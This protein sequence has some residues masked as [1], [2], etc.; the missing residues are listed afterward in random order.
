MWRALD[1]A[2]RRGVAEGA[3]PG[4]VVLAGDSREILFHRAYGH[5]ALAPE[6]LSMM[7]DTV[8]DLSSLTKPVATTTAMMLLVRD[9]RVRL[10]DPVSR[11]IPEFSAEA[12]AAVTFRQLLNHT[13]GLPA[14]KPYYESVVPAPPSVI[15]APS[16]V[17]PAEAGIQAGWGGAARP[18]GPHPPLDSRFRGNDGEGRGNDE[19]SRG[20]DREGRG[21]TGEGPGNEDVGGGRILEQIHAEPLV[22]GPGMGVCYSD[23]GFML[24][25]EAVERLTGKRLDRLCRDEVFVPLELSSTF[26]VD[27]SQPSAVPRQSAGLTIA[28]TED[29]PWRG[30][31]LCGEVHD[32]NAYAMGGVAGHAGVFSSAPDV[33]RFIRF[34]GRCLTDAE[35]DFLPAALIRQFLEAERTLP[36]QTH[37][38]G[39]DT[40]SPEGSSAGR[41]FSPRTVGHL[42][43]TGTSIWWDLERDLHVVFL[44]NRV[45]P[46]RDN[47]A[48]REFRPLVHDAAMEALIS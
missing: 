33:H 46:S 40:P 48:I 8:F 29:C 34:L 25:G 26:F 15:P 43:F 17:I 3:F 32:D 19:A 30:K 37:V 45:H 5:R 31:V 10:D 38:L 16:S 1:E 41:H 2:C 21:N 12:K 22:A 44:T 13:S 27:L 20:N 18:P 6:R 14:W 39:W 11:V 23:L 7:P 24:L 47:G 9:G 4:A 28:A 35:P 42:G 36:G